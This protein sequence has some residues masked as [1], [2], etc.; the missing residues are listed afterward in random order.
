VGGC[1]E[2]RG[3]RGRAGSPKS[4][5]EKFN[6]QSIREQATQVAVL[7]GVDPAQWSLPPEGTRLHTLQP[8]S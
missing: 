1:R 4:R 3:E 8:V 5:R 7:L 6:P 2:S